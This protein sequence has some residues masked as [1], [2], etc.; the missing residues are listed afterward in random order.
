MRIEIKQLGIPK[1]V[2]VKIIK[3]FKW[4]EYQHKH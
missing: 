3:E 2:R 1:I 4:E